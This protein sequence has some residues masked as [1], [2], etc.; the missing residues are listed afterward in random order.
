VADYSVV[1]IT[2]PTMPAA[3]KLARGL[4][5]ARLAA[6]VNIVPSVE[7]HY[8]W[9]GKAEKAKELLLIAKTRKA[10]VPKLADFVRRNHSYSVPEVV[11][12]NVAGGSRPYL[13]WVGG[14]TRPE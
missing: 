6:C 2:C 10:L 5:E 4:L 1:L 11:A 13:D 7:S 14:S 3:R 9:K 8:R 12:L